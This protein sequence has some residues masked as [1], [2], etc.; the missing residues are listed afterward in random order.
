LYGTIR[1]TLKL[2]PLLQ[3]SERLAWREFKERLRPAYLPATF[4]FT[5]LTL[6]LRISAENFVLSEDVSAAAEQE[7]VC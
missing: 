2:L 3:A 6:G 1:S 5:S 4:L 7:T